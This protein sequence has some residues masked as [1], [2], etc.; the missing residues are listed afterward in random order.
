MTDTRAPKLTLGDLP[1][2][3]APQPKP[4]SWVQ[5]ER[6]NHEAWAKLT[7]RSPRAAA[8]AH[9]LTANIDDKHNALVASHEMLSKITGL[10]VATIKRALAD[11]VADRWIQIVKLG[12]KGSA[13]VYV[14][15]DRV[16]W[17]KGRDKLHTSH[18]S[19]TVIA[20]YEEQTHTDDTPLRKLPRLRGGPAA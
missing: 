1:S 16:A 14:V 17:T 13:H 9:Y 6:A 5:T 12:A 2:S 20:D 3:R 8:L 4:R 18:F 7:L 19:A 15:N 11:L 10:S